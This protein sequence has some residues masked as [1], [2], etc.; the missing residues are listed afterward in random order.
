MRNQLACAVYRAATLLLPPDFRR[1]NAPELEHLYREALERAARR[2]V[3]AWTFASL[4]GLWDVVEQSIRSRRGSATNATR[5]SRPVSMPV[6]IMEST[7][8]DLRLAARSLRKSPGFAF[9]AVVMIAVGIGA[10]T[11]LFSVVNAVLLRP[12]RHVAEP[13]RLLSIYTSDY[14]GPAYGASSL[15]DVEDF[16]GETSALA[17]VAAFRPA[18]VSLPSDEGGSELLIAEYVSG[19]YLDV[20]GVEPALGRAFTVEERAPRSGAAVAIIGHGLWTRR[21]GSD[22]DVIGGTLRV[23]GQTLTIIGVAPDGFGGMTPLVTP[24]L[25]IPLS[26]YA[27]IEGPDQLEE[28]G[29]RGW[30]VVAR[31]APEAT[32]GAAQQ[33]LTALAGR[34]GETYPGTW[35][36]VNDETRRVTVVGDIG[37][38][39]QFRGVAV[40]FATL[41]V[42]VFVVTL[43]IACANLANLTLARASRRKREVV[44]KVALGA[45]RL[46]IAGGLLAESAILASIGGAAGVALAWWLLGA[47]LSLPPI[48]GL[49]LTLD[50]SV[51][52]TVLA[53]SAL[54]TVLTVVA[55]GL[56]P[57]IRASRSDPGQALKGERATDSARFRWL[58]LRHL[59]VVGQVAASLVLLVGA[60]LMLK[61]VRAAVRLDT[62]FDVEGIAT[63]DMN[64]GPEGQ[65]A[66]ELFVEVVEELPARVARLPGV[67]AVSLTDALPMTPGA[68]QRTGVQIAGYEPGPGEDM[69]F[70]FHAVGPG[71]MDALGIEM[72]RGR[73]ITEVDDGDAPPVLI[74][75]ESFAERFWPGDDP[76]GKGVRVGRRDAQVVGLMRDILHRDLQDVG[77]P[78]FFVPLAQ[79]PSTHLTMVA[80]TAPGSEDALL[81]LMRAEVRSLDDRLPVAVL[82]TMEQAVS[83]ILLPRR[84]VSWLLSVAG[85]LGMLL[86]AAG[87]YGVMSFLVAQRTREIGLRIALGARA[88][89]VV[90]R[91]VRRGV[92]LSAVG[93]LVGLALAAAVTRLL[94]S[95]LF[96]V[97]PLDPAVFSLMA[98]AAIVVAAAA[99]WL[100]ARRASSVDPMV[101]LR[102]E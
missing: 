56:L 44:M 2:G 67:E 86:S 81:P 58:E 13:D 48:M 29:S 68:A 70:Q 20:L 87:L 11:A 10:N 9:T 61:S 84:L 49:D 7:L 28:R 43:L 91:I 30:S 15:P 3:L 99:S 27:L 76:I 75:N 95:L 57:A 96:D 37:L 46:R 52:R 54:L 77:R 12:P 94:R 38:P 55:A 101:A 63:L 34:L 32:L 100:P 33:Q 80:R 89:D 79:R 8:Q 50:L 45:S 41:L 69:E 74:V 17:E 18:P 83:T 1:R 51:D 64:L 72:V 92:A 62:G 4:R 42:S 19:S 6:S 90:R 73:P 39:P 82:Q 14:S 59:L 31:L 65:E 71:F 85:L 22:P 23:A 16:R 102:H 25:W 53:F 78:A 98:L 24:D 66:F 26:S 40:G 60:G 47:T 35:S 5:T 97:S 36:D 88:G 93:A 21:F